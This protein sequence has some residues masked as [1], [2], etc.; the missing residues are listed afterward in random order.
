MRYNPLK[1]IAYCAE[2]ES[3]ANRCIPWKNKYE[4]KFSDEEN[5]ADKQNSFDANQI[6]GM[7]EKQ[8]QRERQA[9]DFAFIVRVW[10]PV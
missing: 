5:E 8:R 10:I 6:N 7:S 4:P 1:N 9:H 2:H 3:F